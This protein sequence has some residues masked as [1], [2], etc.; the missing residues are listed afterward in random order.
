MIFPLENHW[1]RVAMP[2]VSP[3]LLIRAAQ[4][5]AFRQA[6]LA[7]F[8]ARMVSHSREFFPSRCVALGDEG[9]EQYVRD[10]L[11]EG[12]KHGFVTQRNACQVVNLAFE[13]GL[14]VLREPWA[15]AILS[16]SSLPPPLRLLQLRREAVT[17]RG[18]RQ[19]ADV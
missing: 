8:V 4:E 3:T 13:L 11:R 16:D 15:A 14:D 18:R 6:L 5:D 1:P 19:A 12:A 9:T 7:P 10:A 17:Q 2:N